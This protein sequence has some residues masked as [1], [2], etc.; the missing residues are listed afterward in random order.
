ML[1]VSQL[2]RVS[3]KYQMIN[4]QVDFLGRFQKI[5]SGREK[6]WNTSLEQQTNVGII[7]INS[8]YTTTIEGANVS[9]M[10]AAF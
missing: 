3:E 1:L 6:Q 8:L 7:M 2:K 5:F 4:G 9:A 10:A